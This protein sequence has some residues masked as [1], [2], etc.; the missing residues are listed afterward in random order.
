MGHLKIN[1]SSIFHIL[2]Y[3]SWISSWHVLSS[4]SNPTVDPGAMA[5]VSPGW[6]RRSCPV[7]NL[8]SSAR[9]GPTQKATAG[10]MKKIEQLDL[11]QFFQ[12]NT[13]FDENIIFPECFFL[14]SW[15]GLPLVIHFHG[16][17]HHQPSSYWGTP[18][19]NPWFWTGTHLMHP[20]G[21]V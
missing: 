21:N 15:V 20:S 14:V 3:C 2:S 10:A 4:M 6:T 13:K 18:M 7:L 8:P 17:F 16:I 12:R 1:F 19:V 9:R 5:I 11:H